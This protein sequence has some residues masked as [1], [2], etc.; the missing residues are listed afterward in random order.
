MPET[1]AILLTLM[2]SVV[3]ITLASALCYN[4]V[5]R[6]KHSAKH[7]PNIKIEQFEAR[8]AAIETRLSDIQEIVISIDDQLKRPTRQPSFA[9]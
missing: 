1:V 6:T 4:I 2:T 8:I 7:G 9:D 5:Q 3:V